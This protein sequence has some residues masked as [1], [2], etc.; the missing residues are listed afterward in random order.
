LRWLR[1]ELESGDP[2][3]ARS[4]LVHY[5]KAFPAGRL[6]TEALWLKVRVL[7]AQGEREP[8]RSAAQELVQRFPTTPQAKAA[9][10][11]LDAR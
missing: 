7:Q 2:A 3:A 8:A 10:R 5:Q 11:I 9:R 1:L 4:V 6:E